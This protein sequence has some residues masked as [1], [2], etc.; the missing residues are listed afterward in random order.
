MQ[1][2]RF[3][4]YKHILILSLLPPSI[5]LPFPQEIEAH[6][7]DDP[8][9]TNLDYTLKGFGSDHFEIVENM[10]VAKLRIKKKVRRCKEMGKCNAVQR[11]RQQ[12]ENDTQ[13][14]MTFSRRRELLVPKSKYQKIPENKV[15]QLGRRKKGS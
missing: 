11:E 14:Y 9:S 10:N 2:R 6:D 8:A 4:Q 13:K 1:L 5:F 15:V 12:I 7:L 3:N